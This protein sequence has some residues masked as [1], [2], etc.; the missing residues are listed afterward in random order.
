MTRDVCNM[1]YFAEYLEDKNNTDIYKKLRISSISA[2]N[3]KSY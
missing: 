2:Y 3:S 1:I